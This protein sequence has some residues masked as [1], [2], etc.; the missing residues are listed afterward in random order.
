MTEEEIRRWLR[1][2]G[3]SV[4][5][6][7]LDYMYQVGVGE[8]AVPTLGT[9]YF[10]TA[11][12]IDT[13]VPRKYE[14][15][16]AGTP[17][18]TRALDRATLRGRYLPTVG[19]LEIS[20]DGTYDYLLSLALDGS[21]VRVYIGDPTWARADFVHLFTAIS[22]LA[23][24]P[25]VETIRITL[26]DTGVLLNKRIGGEVAVGGTEPSAN[27]FRPLNRGFVHQLA[28]ILQDSTIPRYVHSE[29]GDGVAQ[30]VRNDGVP[31]TYT[32]NAD[33]TFDLAVPPAGN[34]MIT[35][36]VLAG[37]GTSG[38]DYRASDVIDWMV[39]DRC[40]LTALGLYAGAAP[41]YTVGGFND[42]HLGISITEATNVAQDLLDRV[43]NSVNSFWAINRQGQ[44]YYGQMRPEA[45]SEVVGGSL[46]AIEIEANITADD[47]FVQTVSINHNAPTYTGYQAIGNINWTSQQTF[48]S[49]LTEPERAM[50]T[51][52]GYYTLA[53]FGED[54]GT[55]SYLGPVSF[56][57]GAPQLYH[58]TMSDSQLAETL[59]A[60]PDDTTVID[61]SA[62]PPQSVENYLQD[63]S[64]VRRSQMLPWMEY[65][66]FTAG[67]DMYPLELGDVV[68]VTLPHFDLDAGLLYQ[69]CTIGINAQQR[70]CQLGLVRR[71]YAGVLDIPP[72]SSRELREDGGFELREDGGKELRD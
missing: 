59:I 17:T 46:G 8:S 10:S 28:P 65:I 18:F 62:V 4:I 33:G 5:L 29:S 32:D 2:A 54:P 12:Y 41:T 20:N 49:S 23:A 40:G 1:K 16:V 51:R 60:G 52:K 27:R 57:G 44:F 30:E 71:R 63:W 55:T 64:S 72:N 43:M 39:G 9:K 36:D 67:L 24:A 31:V 37:A 56:R 6:V 47:L 48:A 61:G 53:Y 50:F 22:L 38:V 42:Y 35:A 26:R 19:A 3:P 7:E 70:Q 25:A 11:P 13:S 69:V 21:Q 68:N 15:C 14:D 66:D 45:L 34:E 58:L